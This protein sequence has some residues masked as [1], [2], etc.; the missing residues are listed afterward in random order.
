M[1]ELQKKKVVE[2]KQIARKHIGK[3]FSKL[4][5]KAELI[6]ALSNIPEVME[7]M[8]NIQK[9]R[10]I[11]DE[12]I[13][14]INVRVLKPPK[15]KPEQKPKPTTI[16]IKN[17]ESKVVDPIM[18]DINKFADWILSYVPEPPKKIVDKRI[19]SMKEK[20]NKIFKRLNQKE[21]SNE[22]VDQI[23]KSFTPK[24]SLK[25]RFKRIFKKPTTEYEKEEDFTPIEQE[26][27]FDGYLKT[28]RIYGNK[29]Y[30][31]KKFMKKIKPK[32]ID[33]INQQKKPLK[34]KFIIVCKFIKENPNTLNFDEASPPFHTKQPETITESTDFSNLFD[35]MTNHQLEVFKRFTENGSGWVFDH[36]EY[37]DIKIDP[38]E[39]LLGSSYIPLPKNLA[40]KKSIVNPKNE[41]DNKCF[42]HAVTELVLIPEMFT[43]R[44]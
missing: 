17:L 31:E 32:V 34:V 24:E 33:L 4:K 22:K 15:P 11:L 10:I 39:P 20:F 8:R 2:L 35:V 29:R 42:K 26:T 9:Q 18:K 21:N 5:L 44:G 1:E 28:Y 43:G 6:E 12:P 23:R 13:P 19:E 41:N 14:K 37:F 7:E 16:P 36:V 27:A 38:F 25:E 3:G 40:N 30:D